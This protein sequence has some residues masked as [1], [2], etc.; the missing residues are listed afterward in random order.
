MGN[1]FGLIAEV[2][3]DDGTLSAADIQGLR[4]AHVSAPARDDYAFDL[5]RALAMSGKYP[6]AR[7]VLGML[8]G[9]PH[10]QS[11]RDSAIRMMR[12]VVDLE[13]RAAQPASLA[14]S[15]P[16]KTTPETAPPAPDTTNEPPAA[17][18]DKNERDVEP[19]YREVQAG[20]QR[21]EGLLER[22]DCATGN[23]TV[24]TVRYPDRVA[25]LVAAFKRAV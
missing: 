19:F 17:T 9:H 5:A 13:Q 12:W 11:S 24:V 25:R 16:E 7:N 3:G 14:A 20:E 1:M 10:W 21:A 18:S 4:Q 2:A 22:V 8:I 23:P 15:E 6:D